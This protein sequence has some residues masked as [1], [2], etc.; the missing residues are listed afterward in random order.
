MTSIP[1]RSSSRS[2]RPTHLEGVVSYNGS[3]RGFGS[4]IAALRALPGGKRP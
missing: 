2:E 3:N 4:F 1:L